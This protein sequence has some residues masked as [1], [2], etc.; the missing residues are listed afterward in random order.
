MG[1]PLAIGTGEIST[2]ENPSVT[3]MMRQAFPELAAA[4]RNRTSRILEHFRAA[5]KDVLPSADEL[6]FAE[7]LDH[8]PHAIE[9]LAVALAATGGTLQARFI[10][11][12]RQHGTCRYHQSFNLS[13]LLVEYSIL[14]SLIIDEVSK[15]LE[16]FPTLEEISALNAGMDAA[17]RR[18][19]ES[20]VNNFQHEVQA[21][22]EAQSK[23]LSFLSHDLRGSLNGILLAV[24]VL[25]RTKLET[26]SAEFLSDLEIMR[27]SIMDTVSAMDR[28]LH[29]DKLRRRK[30][31]VKLAE[32]DLEA[33]IGEI[34]LQFSEQTKG[35]GV[36][37]EVTTA[38]CPKV[39]SDRGLVQLVLQNLMGNAVK[40]TM[41]GSIRIIT[42]H[43]SRGGCRVTV[44][45]T[46]PGI[47]KEQLSQ[48]FQPYMRGPTHGQA[49]LGLGLTI[50][51]EAAVIL[52]ARLW[53][54]SQLG[55]GTSFHFDLPG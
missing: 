33:L 11:D 34:A 55:V 20:F 40:Y 42:T 13:E 43:L 22:A 36:A 46:G 47:P 5:V 14:R 1:V 50:A 29:A 6:T 48:I 49:G 17:S 39:V 27:R 41:Q 51:H 19:V 45:D 31:E 10:S 3:L 53:A 4:L 7:L 25:R 9:D 16:R 12:S 30:V 21:G 52:K 38:N 28:F 44:A 8:L 18:A 15:D 54:E 32:V 2:V 24:E 26:P 35:K 37:I 23:Y